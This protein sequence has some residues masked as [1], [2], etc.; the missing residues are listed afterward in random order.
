MI[1]QF[2][3]VDQVVRQTSGLYTL[4]A[5]A[6]KVLELTGQDSVD[7]R[8]LKECI[9]NDPALTGK[10]LKV[11]NS[12]L[13]GLGSEVHGLG[14]ALAL[15]GTKP[16]KL[17]VLG[18]SLPD[19]LFT[20]IGHDRLAAFWRDALTKAVAAREICQRWW[21]IPGDEAF[22][23]GLL[24]DIGILVLLQD[25][26]EPYLELL[27]Q[28]DRQGSDLERQ[29]MAIL[30]FNHSTLSAR[31][32]DTWSLPKS[33]V[34]AIAAP[35]SFATLRGLAGEQAVLPRILH[36]SDLLVQLVARHRIGALPELLE[37]GKAYC[38]LT[39][40]ALTELVGDLEQH[41]DQLADVLSLDLPDGLGFDEVLA[42]AHVRLADEVEELAMGAVDKRLPSGALGRCRFPTGRSGPSSTAATGIQVPSHATQPGHSDRAATIPGG[43]DAPQADL[44]LVGTLTAVIT[45]CRAGRHGLSL[46]LIEPVE[47]PRWGN[48]MGSETAPDL[49]DS[50][51][52]ECGAI[53]PRE[54][55]VLPTGKT[56]LAMILPACERHAAVEIAHRLVG[57]ATQRY[58]VD[59]SQ[60][61]SSVNLC[62]GVASVALPSKNFRARDLIEC[63]QRC[64]F[65]GR[66]SSGPTVKSIEV[67]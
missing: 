40:P 43:V 51:K 35:K 63:A 55:A 3:S 20:G 29:E 52:R 23:A 11:V 53:C 50:V 64:L 36:L 17:L 19:R 9:E 26:R 49:V 4:P 31:L 61:R 66:T 65:A 58:Q 25:L 60:R 59:P 45:N 44:V 2:P 67:Y 14:Q 42:E 30:G 47:R 7:S 46:L 27:E 37:A 16:L 21:R 24:Q 22:I 28:V 54:G 18:F 38:R 10:L 32:L 13:F 12:S 39:R 57:R 1:D 15:L 41:V 6:M 8:A 48:Q 62:I 56:G 5:V 33:L 34:R